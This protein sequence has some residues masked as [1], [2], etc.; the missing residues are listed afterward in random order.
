M[1]LT[2]G[3]GNSGRLWC[4]ASLPPAG[5]AG[6]AACRSCLTKGKHADLQGT[7]CPPTILH[8]MAQALQDAY[9]SESNPRMLD[10]CSISASV[11]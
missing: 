2:G 4:F 7:L 1:A 3:L 9:N 11:A 6:K 5:R 10:F 8:T